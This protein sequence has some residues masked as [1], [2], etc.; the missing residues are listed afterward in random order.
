MA[1]IE[2]GSSMNGSVVPDNALVTEPNKYGMPVVWPYRDFQG[3]T[4]IRC[5]LPGAEG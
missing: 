1:I 4:Q 5:F 2:C 3:N